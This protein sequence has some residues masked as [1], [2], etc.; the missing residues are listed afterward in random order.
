MEVRQALA[1]RLRRR[2][3]ALGLSLT[4]LS[5]QT[6]IPLQVLSRLEHGRQSI[7]ME[8]LAVLARFLGVTTDY[9]LGLSDKSGAENE[10]VPTALVLAGT[11]PARQYSLVSRSER[12]G[13]V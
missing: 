2:R 8:R 3:M 9:L 12:P 10:R 7:Y 6:Q 5:E 4:D 11:Q 1:H 13:R